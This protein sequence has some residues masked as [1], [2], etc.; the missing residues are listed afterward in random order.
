M[1]RKKSAPVTPEPVDVASGED[2]SRS[3]LEKK[4]VDSQGR[5]KP[6]DDRIEGEQVSTWAARVSQAETDN[7]AW[8]KAIKKQR[9]YVNGTQ[10]DDGEKG[11]VRTN[12]IY[13][14][15]ATNCPHI[16]AKDPE[17]EVNLTDAVPKEQ[18]RVY[19]GFAK[20]LQSILDSLFTRG[21]RLKVRAK[22]AV[23]GTMTT[24][25]GWCKVI[26]QEDVRADPLTMARLNDSQDNIQ[27]T[28]ALIQQIRKGEEE[29]DLGDL[30]AKKLELQMQIAAFNTE[31]ELNT[32][33]G[34]VCD[35]ILSEDMLIL[36]PSI[37]DFDYYVEAD[38]LAMGLWVTADKYQELFGYVLPEGATT[39]LA[40]S[41][42]PDETPAAL[43]SNAATGGKKPPVWYRVFE[44]WHKGSNTVYTYAKGAKVWA[45]EPY[46]PAHVGKRWYPFF[47][48]GF[49]PVDGQWRPMSDVE[50]LTELQ[51]EYNTTRTNYAEARKSAIPVLI[52]RKGGDLTEKD[53]ENIKNRKINQIIAIE[54][55]PGQPIANEIAF[56]PTADINPEVYDTSPIRADFEQVSGTADA[57]RGNIEKVKTATEADI[58]Q[59]GLMSRTDER[60]DVME[61]WF[62]EMAQY[63]AEMLLDALTPIQ[64][65]RL[66]GE[67]AA[68]NWPKLSRDRIF[69]MVQLRIKA[70]SSGKPNAQKERETWIQ[71]LPIIQETITKVFEL[72]ASG[73]YA[74][75]KT[76]MELL[77]E[78]LTRFDEY[79]DLDRFIPPEMQ[80]GDGSD[81][82]TMMMQQQAKLT[83]QL[84]AIQ[85]ELQKCQDELAKAQAAA[86]K[87]Q[88]GEQLKMQQSGEA[89]QLAMEQQRAED[90]RKA[91]EL[92]AKRAEQRSKNS[93][94][95][96]AQ[97]RQIQAD[98]RATVAQIA[99]AER[100][101]LA[102]L[103]VQDKHEAGKLKAEKEAGAAD[104]AAQQ[105]EGAAARSS[106]EKIAGDKN[107]SSETVAQ[108][109]DK[110]TLAAGKD[111][112]KTAVSVAGDKNKT[113]VAT[114][115]MGHQAD[116]AA[117]ESE[118]AVPPG[119]GKILALLA[120][121]ISGLSEA[122][123]ADQVPVRGADG[124]IDRVKKVPRAKPKA[125]AKAT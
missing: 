25:V 104:R 119:E 43:P 46:Q 109:K 111:K 80:E 24:G 64:V 67:E 121:A 12:L 37:K 79:I 92:E 40:P 115:K 39:H 14:T 20:S 105:A 72:Q 112:N 56:L 26:Y 61:D 22:S 102:R 42:D 28:L 81:P 118:G 59:Q 3:A 85:E 52:V 100:I 44:I 53:I 78:T 51:D 95:A 16:Y 82:A 116:A 68:A 70:G 117:A 5:R 19:K 47:C 83:Q 73:G 75:A 99:S 41:T 114:A 71:L 94:E 98:E 123:L 7:D 65:A 63:S 48:L 30:Q 87:A 58:L 101:E 36:D 55:T 33:H 60:K 103:A 93:Q 13:S 69:E 15:I 110:T 10:H 34:L 1:A 66:V 31:N 27:K 90:A 108:G 86:A 8:Y 57:A 35:R 74:L 107:K 89:H 124:K 2:K 77:G 113:T 21:A 32:V 106:S 97:N 125:K 18:Y 4:D 49:N 84:Q 122:L 88:M 29:G 62:G 54:G 17:I 11:L 6:V 45:R 50:L 96:L 76:S 91:Q 9:G 23:R 120:E 38:A